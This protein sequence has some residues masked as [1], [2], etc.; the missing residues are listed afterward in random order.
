MLDLCF[1]YGE[2][3]LDTAFLLLDLVFEV[4]DVLLLV[5]QQKYQVLGEN[6]TFISVQEGQLRGWALDRYSWAGNV[7]R[8]DGFLVVW[9]AGALEAGIG[10]FG[11]TAIVFSLA[12]EAD[13]WAG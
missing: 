13:I 1:E 8:H 6:V 11:E 12:I 4:V 10:E 9:L 5:L 2:V 3:V 7:I